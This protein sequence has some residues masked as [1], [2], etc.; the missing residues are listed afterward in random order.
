MLPQAKIFLHSYGCQMNLYDGELVSSLLTRE[1]FALTSSLEDAQVILFNTC[2]VRDHAEKRVL[3]R[4]NTLAA[5]KRRRP[6]LIIGVLGCMGQRLGEGMKEIAPAVDLVLAPD[7][8]RNLPGILHDKLD[9]SNGH[10]YFCSGDPDETY[11]DVMPQRREGLNA[12]VAI[13]RGCDNFCSFCIVPYARGRERSRPAEQI[14]SEICQAVADGFAEVTLLGQNVNSYRCDDVDFPDL[15][16]RVSRVEGLQRIRFMTSHPRDLGNKLIEVMAQGGKVCPSLHLPAQS[17]SDRVLALMQRGYTRAEYLRKVDLL[18]REV[19]NL[20]L[21]TDLLCGFPTESED[22]FRQTLDLMEAAAFDGAFTFK[23]SP[24]PGT[25]AA[26]M[27]DDVPETVKLER[28]EQMISLSRRLADQ[29]HRRMTGKEVE[30]LLEAP[31][32]QDAGEWTGRTACGRVALTPGRFSAGQT[33]KI[34][35]ESLR[36]F[37]LWGQVLS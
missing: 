29:S 25:T 34:R 5:L 32:P 21:S 23:Y 27:E 4:I 31:S 35:V 12:F 7:A 19:E 22:D 17:G 10:H 30:V 15:L 14:I 13:M 2:S 24:R 3:G 36:G 37:S 8:Y 28:L 1:G 18:R 9:G 6:E 16:L 26:Q 20:A 33:V 11:G